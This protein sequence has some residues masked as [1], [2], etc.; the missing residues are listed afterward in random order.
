MGVVFVPDTARTGDAR[1]GVL[2][3]PV[4]VARTGPGGTGLVPGRVVRLDASGA[5]AATRSTAYGIWD[6]WL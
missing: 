3:R 2:T 4:G 6:S 1:S 5:E